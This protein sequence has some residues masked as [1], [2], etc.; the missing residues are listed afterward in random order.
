MDKKNMISLVVLMVLLMVCILLMG[1]SLLIKERT[2]G[3]ISGY[4]AIA[5]VVITII[6]VVIIMLSGRNKKDK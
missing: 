3:Q 2:F 1:V 6:G 5:C 4:I